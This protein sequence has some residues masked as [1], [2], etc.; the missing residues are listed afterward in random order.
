M[1]LLFAAA[2]LSLAG[3]GAQAQTTTD[4]MAPGGDPAKTIAQNVAESPV[5][6]TLA[7]GLEAAGLTATLAGAGPF[8]VFAPTDD[9]F[10]TL[11]AGLVDEMLQPA[12]KAELTT[13]LLCHVVEG[14]FVTNDL[15]EMKAAG[16]AG[17]DGVVIDT[18]GGCKLTVRLTEAGG[19]TVTDENGTV[20]NVT[21]PDVLQ[22]N[23]VV[24][25]IDAI[26]GPAGM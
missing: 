8:T 9:V 3:F 25:V 22:A 12:N 6:T 11:P 10:A 15:V 5:H 14:Q 26:M 4:A 20:A 19:V 16:K 7:R 1:R 18:L 24:H 21:V 17:P 23:G 13:S 2:A